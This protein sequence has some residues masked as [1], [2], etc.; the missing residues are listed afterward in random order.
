[1]QWFRVGSVSIF[2]L[3]SSRAT[4][5]ITDLLVVFLLLIHT[6]AS[7][8]TNAAAAVCVGPGGFDGRVVQQV[9]DSMTGL[10]GI[11]LHLG[12]GFPAATTDGSGKV[13]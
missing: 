11:L 5:R 7:N 12:A 9:G 1:M 13:R 6:Q 3:L 8:F 10:L 2:F 4:K